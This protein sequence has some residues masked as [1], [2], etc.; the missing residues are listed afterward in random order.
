MRL[1]HEVVQGAVMQ[2]FM[3]FRIPVDGSLFV[4]DLRSEWDRTLLRNADM[5]QALI[6]LVDSGHLKAEDSSEGPLLR[7]TASGHAYASALPAGPRGDWIRFLTAVVL[8]LVRR[9]PQPGVAG[10]RRAEDAL[11]SAA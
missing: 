4:S 10:R 9:R 2:I 6:Q 3:N 1:G 8:P 11:R 7:L 5:A